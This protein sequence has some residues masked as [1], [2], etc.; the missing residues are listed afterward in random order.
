MRRPGRMLAA[1]GVALALL[2]AGQ[3]HPFEL[4][5]FGLGQVLQDAA[6]A[7]ART[8]LIGIGGSA[9]N[10]GGFGLARSVGWQFVDGSGQAITQWTDLGSLAAVHPPGRRHWFRRLLVAVDVQNRLLGPQGATRIYGPQK[11]LTPRDFLPAERCLRRLDRIMTK[12][13]GVRAAAEPGTGAAGGLGFGLR[14]FLG[15]DLRPG[16]GL[17]ARYA[18]LRQHLRSVQLVIT[19]EGAMDASTLMGKGVGEIATCCRQLQVPCIGLAGI[20]RNSSQLAR[21]FTR[22]SG[23][24][25]GLT[26]VAHARQ[27]PAVWLARLASRIA[28]SLPCN[29]IP[30]NRAI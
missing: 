8:C 1:L 15:A 3:Y 26:D 21:R 25:P 11:G 7:G 5:T 10:D 14:C 19:G 6:N 20:L 24:A 29:A 27:Q 28:T 17:F 30:E 23:M 2:P 18:R 22:V 12:T 9:T 13:F 4:D 16:F